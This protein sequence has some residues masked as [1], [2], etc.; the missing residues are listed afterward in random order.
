MKNIRGIALFWA[1]AALTGMAAIYM[2]VSIMGQMPTISKDGYISKLLPVQGKLF[3]FVTIPLMAF[4]IRYFTELVKNGYEIMVRNLWG[5]IKFGVFV[6]AMALIMTSH[7]LNA[8]YLPAL[9]IFELILMIFGPFFTSDHL[10]GVIIA[11][12]SNMVLVLFYFVSVTSYKA[13]MLILLPGIAVTLLFVNMVAFSILPF[14]GS[15]L[16]RI[17]SK[18]FWKSAKVG[19]QQAIQQ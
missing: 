13:D 10:E 18:E 6:G 12:V 16:E 17:F 11:T 7:Q 4:A 3:W 1:I 14:F 15:I 2:F 9:L 19:L 5:Y 8:E